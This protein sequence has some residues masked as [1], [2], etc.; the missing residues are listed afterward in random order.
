LRFYICERL[1]NHPGW[2]GLEV[3]F[4]DASAPGEGEHKI[5]QFIR[6]QRAQPGYDPHTRHV[7]HGLDA[8]LIMLG[9]ATHEAHFSILREQVFPKRVRGGRRA[10]KEV[11]EKFR[12]ENLARRRLIF[13]DGDVGV[14]LKPLQLL[15]IS[16]L[17]EYLAAEF[18][19]LNPASDPTLRAQMAR[20]AEGG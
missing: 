5:M 7:L 14:P 1:N 4:S 18:A 20:A 2:A 13:R 3:V 8:D 12:R 15:Q 9:L 19:P 11:D 6:G 17:R 10:Q 16:V